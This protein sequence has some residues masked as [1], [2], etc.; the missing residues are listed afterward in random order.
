MSKNGGRGR[1]EFVVVVVVVVMRVVVLGVVV[2][3]VVVL[4]VVVVGSRWGSLGVVV[5]ESRG[6]RSRKCARRTF[7]T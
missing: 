7:L 4:G 2:M 3:G 1:R 6:R 5:V